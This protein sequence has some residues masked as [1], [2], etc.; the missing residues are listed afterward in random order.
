MS[1]QNKKSV[2]VI[3]VLQK[4]KLLKLPNFYPLN[5]KSI[6]CGYGACSASDCN[7]K[8]YEGSGQ[9]C[10]NCGYNYSKHW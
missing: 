4:D 9:T 6:H 7:C 5:P 2:S 10:E 8:G 3:D 1:L